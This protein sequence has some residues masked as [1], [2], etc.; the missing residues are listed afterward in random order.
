[1]PARGWPLGEDAQAQ[2]WRFQSDLCAAI[3]HD[4]RRAET[5]GVRVVRMRFG[6]VLGHGG[7]PYP[8]LA[9]AARFG[10]A[11][12]IGDGK[13]PVPWIHVADAVDLVRFAIDKP[14]VYG[15]I[16]AVAP[17]IVRQAAFTKT[18]AR[19]FG[20]PAFLRVPG[21]LLRTAM[22]EM[23]ELL[24]CGQIVLPRAAQAAGFAFRYRSLTDATRQLAAR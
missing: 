15:A 12:R 11:A 7:G 14:H 10:G 5:L 22:G 1:M 17:E 4:A 2:P 16:N 20:R 18:L 8:P 9:L 13:Q 21:W 19:S 23:S 24:L 3:E 6:L